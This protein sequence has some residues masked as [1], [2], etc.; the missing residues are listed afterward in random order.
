MSRRPAITGRSA[1]SETAIGTAGSGTGGGIK[2]RT[3][4]DFFVREMAPSVYNLAIAD[5]R[6]Y[7]EHVEVSLHRPCA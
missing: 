6:R 4:L 7:F 5:V 3:V 1:R 2:A